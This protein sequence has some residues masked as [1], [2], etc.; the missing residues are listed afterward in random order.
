MG[1]NWR[2]N[3]FKVPVKTP[4]KLD[5]FIPED[6]PPD[7]ESPKASPP[8]EDVTI[9]DTLPKPW[10]KSEELGKIV[11]NL[12]YHWLLNKGSWQQRTTSENPSP[13]DDDNPPIEDKINA[14]SVCKTELP[15]RDQFKY[16]DL[17]LS[18]PEKLENFTEIAEMGNNEFN[19]SRLRF[20]FNKL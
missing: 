10:K 11:S 9:K 7:K 6:K 4:K 12:G 19:T 20:G 14:N 18:P 1:W 16:P 15:Y 3:S 17:D 13:D 8:P 5:N 2:W